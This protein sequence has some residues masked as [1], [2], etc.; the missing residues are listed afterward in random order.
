MC[1]RQKKT[2]CVSESTIS[3]QVRARMRGND[4]YS[5]ADRCVMG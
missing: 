4:I 1:V 3:L 5:I 2:A